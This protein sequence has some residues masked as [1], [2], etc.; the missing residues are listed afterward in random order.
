MSSS[1]PSLRRKR[2]VCSC[3]QPFEVWVKTYRDGPRLCES[4]RTSNRTARDRRRQSLLKQGVGINADMVREDQEQAEREHTES[5][6]D[7]AI[8]MMMRRG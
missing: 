2:R 8:R 6:H 4:C 3:G 7:L 1:D 5:N